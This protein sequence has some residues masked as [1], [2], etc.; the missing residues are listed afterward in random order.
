MRMLLPLEG[1]HAILTKPAAEANGHCF[2]DADVLADAGVTDLSG[3][4]GGDNPV[5]DIFLNRP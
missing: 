1:D 3:Y 2:I 4:D 5:W